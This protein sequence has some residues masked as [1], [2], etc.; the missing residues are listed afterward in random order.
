[1]P[2]LGDARAMCG[3]LT[4]MCGRN[5]SMLF[6]REHRPEE[7]DEL[8]ALLLGLSRRALGYPAS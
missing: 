7:E 2:G 5:F 3:T 4:Y 8:C 6:S 1:M